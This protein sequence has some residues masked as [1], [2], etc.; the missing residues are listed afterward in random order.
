[1]I[2]KAEIDFVDESGGLEGVVR[3]FIP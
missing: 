1:L 3:A 2:E